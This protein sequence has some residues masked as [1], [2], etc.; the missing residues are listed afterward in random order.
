[1]YW[2]DRLQSDNRE[3]RQTLLRCHAPAL[4]EQICQ[5]V[6]EKAWQH[7]RTCSGHAGQLHQHAQSEHPWIG[8]C[9]QAR[10]DGRAHLQFEEVHE[11]ALE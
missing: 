5:T 6:D 3:H 8:Q 10:A 1:M 7:G 2:K 11:M 9:Q 4:E